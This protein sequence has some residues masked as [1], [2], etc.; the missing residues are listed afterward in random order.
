[1]VNEGALFLFFAFGMCVM[2]PIAILAAVVY[3]VTRRARQ[4]H[5]ERM[6]LIAQGLSPDG[7]PPPPPAPDAPPGAPVPPRPPA[8]D[9]RSDGLAWAVGLLVCGLLWAVGCAHFAAML[10][11]AGA[12][13][14]TR[15]ILGMKRDRE[16][17]DDPNVPP[18]GVR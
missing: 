2:V 17:M 18:G 12:G 5:E 16:A 7:A 11:G 9:D 1:M 4:R 6:A 15:G 3:L 13:F 8:R 10:L 14:L